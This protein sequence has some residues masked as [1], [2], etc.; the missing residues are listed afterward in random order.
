MRYELANLSFMLLLM[1]A[2]IAAA[3]AVGWPW[4]GVLLTG[5]GSFP[6]AG[7]VV[8]RTVPGTRLLDALGL[9][10]PAGPRR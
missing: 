6:V 5:V 9:G 7:F 2:A 1:A 4:W 8:E 10:R 3:V